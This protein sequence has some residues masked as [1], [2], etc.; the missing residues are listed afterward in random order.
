M[1]DMVIQGQRTQHPEDLRR[2]GDQSGP[3]PPMAVR[4][5]TPVGTTPYKNLGMPAQTRG[6]SGLRRCHACEGQRNGASFEGVAK[7]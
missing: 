7:P 4:V 1:T 2:A 6:L 5:R 3:Y